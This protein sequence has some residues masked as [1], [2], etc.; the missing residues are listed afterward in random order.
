MNRV[1]PFSSKLG[2]GIGQLAEGVT[3]AAFG[4]FLLFFYN[5]ILGISGAL[6]GLALGIA[7]FCDAIT[8]PLAGSISDRLNTRWGRR[9][10]MMA[11]SSLP[12]AMCVVALFNPPSGM[13]DWFYFGWLVVFAVLARTFLTL[14]HIPHLA[15]GAEM[16]HDYLDRTRVFSYSQLFGSLG[17]T[18]FGFVMLTFFFVSSEEYAHGMLNQTAYTPFSL[19]A[20]VI[21]MISIWL[22]V[23]G[24]AKEIPY[25]PKATFKTQERLSF[26]R[27]AREMITAF[28]NHSY[29]MLVGGLF[30]A[31]IL[32]GIEGV[33]MVYMYVHFWGMETENMRWLGPTGL[34]ALPFSVLLAPILTKRFDKRHL[35]IGLSALIIVNNNTMIC[36]ALFT[37]IL[38]PNGT[39]LLLSM[40]LSFVFLSGLCSPAVII[41]LNSMFADIADEQELITGERQEGIIFSARS[42]SFK[43]G[44][45]VASII[46][47]VALDLIGFPRGAAP[48]EVEADVLFRLGLVAGPLTSI[49]GLFILLFYLAYRL[50][51]NRV[52]EIQAELAIR[53][54]ETAAQ[55]EP[56]QQAEASQQPDTA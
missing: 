25:L 18:G 9:L 26:G 17:S 6:T 2:F 12:L 7:L 29:R 51:R 24:T 33:F 48:G 37:D 11:A 5:Q 16:A 3:L 50:D 52:A 10:P 34:L 35:L 47:G 13:S 55:S 20:A 42:F 22:S 39:I 27:L 46:G 14:Y 38:P 43:A 41:T 30:C 32:L 19:S 21:I 49:L 44:G 31:V 36:L 15:L 56:G 8:D 28:K 54:A 45:A 1:L 53:R 40:L 23:F 4:T